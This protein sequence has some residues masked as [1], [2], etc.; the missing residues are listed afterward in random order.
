MLLT[1]T[2]FISTSGPLGKYIDM[3][4]EVVIWWRS[5]LAMLFLFIYCKYQNISLKIHSRKDY[6]S[7][8]ISAFFL[9]AH[10]ITYFYALKLSNVAIGMLSLFTFPVM[11]ALLEPL[12]VKTK[13]DPIHVLLGIMVLFGVYLL[14]PKFEIQSSYFQGILFGLLSAFCYALRV[15][16]LKRHI[17]SYNG[18]ALMW[19]QLLVLAIVLSPYLVL[20]D[21]S[22]ITTQYPFILLL[23]LLT[24]AVGHTLF[25]KSL[26]HFSASTAS[27]IASAQPLFGI[28]L[29]FFFL[30]EIPSLNTFFGGILILATVIIES[31]RS[32]KK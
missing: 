11:T 15:L 9:G 30:N 28:I 8:A 16:I 32:R 18:T 26:K 20:M 4:S 1:A 22:N 2:L 5:S 31:L 23:G 7:I 12:F 13:F 27:I 14:A 19:H 25:L 21:T 24:T 29:A 17:A 6:L 10:W 3:P